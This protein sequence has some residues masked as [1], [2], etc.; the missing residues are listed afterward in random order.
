MA[1]VILSHVEKIYDNGFHAVHD[2]TLEV[3]DGEFMVFVGPSG[4][5]KST[6]MRMIAGLESISSGTIQIGDRIVNRIPPKDR[7]VAM[8]FQDYALYPHMTVRENMSLSLKLR[9]VPKQE[10]EKRVLHAAKVLDIDHV[11]DRKPKEL[12]GGQ[13]QRVAV[14]RAIVRTPDVFM[15]DEPLSNLDPKLR[16]TMRVE[17]KKLHLTL[18]TTMIYVTHDQLEAM[19]LADRIVVMNQGR[20]Q[21]VGTP[22]EV[23]SKPANKF[24][25]GFIGT[26]PMNFFSCEVIRENGTVHLKS[27][28]FDFHVNRDHPLYQKLQERGIS[29]SS[30]WTLGIRPEHMELARGKAG[31]NQIQAIV[32]VM[33]PMA[34]EVFVHLTSESGE[35]VLRD[36]GLLKP[37]IR[38]GQKVKVNVDMDN[39]HLFDEEGIAL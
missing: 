24:V 13:R 35:F 36:D 7:N 16:T 12:S 21:Q 33:E 31:E 17:L 2:F 34:P 29:A 19:T 26:P 39:I 38:P 4:C 28:G 37:V 18:K 15:F 10:I 3:Q 8:V 20:I 25:A 6:T 11:L 23:Y 30:G 22:L 1:S 5:G 14:G 32:E 9:K 27:D